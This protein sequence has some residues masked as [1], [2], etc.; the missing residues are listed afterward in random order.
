[1]MNYLGGITLGWLITA[2]VFVYLPDEH[3]AKAKAMKETCEQKLSR[4]Q[5][6]VMQFVPEKK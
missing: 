3:I 4:E 1:M 2:L 6:C 5:Q